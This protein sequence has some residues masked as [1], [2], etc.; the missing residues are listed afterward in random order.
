VG[1]KRVASTFS[2]TYS[3]TFYLYNSAFA[4]AAAALSPGIMIVVL[5][6]RRCIEQGMRRFDFLR[7]TER[8][9]FELGAERLP[10]HAVK[11]TRPDS[12]LGPCG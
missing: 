7:G 11:I 1:G 9:K 4:A 6:I 3:G 12:A 5:L 10:L 8:Y 2:F